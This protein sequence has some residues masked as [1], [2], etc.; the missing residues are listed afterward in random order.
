MDERQFLPAHLELIE[1]PVSAAPK[2]VARL[3]ILFILAAFI[4]AMVGQVE[5]VAVA[6]GK[7]VPAGNSKTIQPLETSVIKKI[8]VKDGDRV[9]AGDHLIDLEGIGSDSDFNQSMRQLEAALLTRLRNQAL[10][11]GLDS[12][13]LPFFTQQ[14]KESYTFNEKELTEAEHLLQNQYQTWLMQD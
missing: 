4:W 3:I 9:N 13:T 2:A 6:T 7:T 10:L 11:R 12:K 5:I 14:E 8:Y 1:T